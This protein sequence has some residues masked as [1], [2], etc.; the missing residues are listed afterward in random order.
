MCCWRGAPSEAG[1]A[2]SRLAVAALLAL[3]IA[4]PGAARAQDSVATELALILNLP[5][6]RLDVVR[7]GR[8]ETSYRVAIGQ[9]EFPTPTGEFLVSAAE[10]N[11]WWVP[12]AREWTKGQ[13]PMPP[14]P[15][16]PMGRVKLFFRAFYYLHGTPDS[17]SIGRAASHGCVRLG[18][19]DA[20]A[21]A[22]TLIRVGVPSIEP[23]RLAAMAADRVAT[24]SV[25]FERRIPLA[26][27]YRVVEPAGDSVRIHPNPYRW[28]PAQILEALRAE[29]PA[30]AV[31]GERL[32]RLLE[33]ARDG[34]ITVPS[35][36]LIE[37]R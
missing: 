11:P 18:N 25:P 21:L 23:E 28:S 4:A 6:S 37:P 12:P 14:G 1:P 19:G 32:E 5:A 15:T 17:G 31:P 16:N 29:R 9:P 2:R 22:T 8:I 13:E 7:E 35:R 27:E 30:L 26:I 10:W 36:E 33:A 34:T 3:A 20:V 24:L